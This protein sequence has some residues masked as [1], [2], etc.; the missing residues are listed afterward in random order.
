MLAP[1]EQGQLQAF[2]A[3][4]LFTFPVHHATAL[5]GSLPKPARSYVRN[6]IC[7]DCKWVTQCTAYN[8]VEE[9]HQVPHLNDNPDFDPKN[10]SIQ[11]FIRPEGMFEVSQEFDV[12][13]CDSFAFEKGAWQKV[14]PDEPIPT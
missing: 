8:F 4:S 13:A 5:R 11:V 3:L 6:C 7:V 1:K 12:F 9:Q 14:R 10:T 2:S